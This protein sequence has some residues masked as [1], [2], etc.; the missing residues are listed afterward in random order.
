[1]HEVTEMGMGL[2]FVGMVVKWMGMVWCFE[3]LSSAWGWDEGGKNYWEWCGTG[4]DFHYRVT[5]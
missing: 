2:C 3:C 5:L 4:G 1:M